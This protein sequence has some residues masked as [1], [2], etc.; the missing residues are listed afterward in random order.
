MPIRTSGD[1]IKAVRVKLG[2]YDY[3]DPENKKILNRIGL[4]LKNQTV[5]NI[6]KQD[7]RAEGHLRASINYKIVTSSD[8]SATVEYGSY[9]I[10]YAALHEYGGPFTSAMR[11]AMFAKFAERDKNSKGPKKPFVNK[12]LIEGGYMKARPY[13]RP[14]L[15]QQHQRILEILRGD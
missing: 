2:R 11:R 6:N 13:M 15:V 1:L 7:V 5:L 3:S 14:A 8:G 9:G 10:I 4:L 12:R